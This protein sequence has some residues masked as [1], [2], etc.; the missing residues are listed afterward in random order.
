MLR[1]KVFKKWKVMVDINFVLK[2]LEN[3][4]VENASKNNKHYLTD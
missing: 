1:L 4:I 2:K 3:K